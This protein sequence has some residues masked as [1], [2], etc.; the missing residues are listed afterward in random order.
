MYAKPETA[1]FLDQRMRGRSAWLRDQG[2]LCPGEVSDSVCL[3]KRSTSYS[4][5]YPSADGLVSQQKS[6][7][8]QTLEGGLHL[9]SIIQKDL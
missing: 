6:I 9:L 4:D 1:G 5:H 7:L 2:S 3:A 8:N